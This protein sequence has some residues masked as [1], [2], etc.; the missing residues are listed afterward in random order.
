M[1]RRDFLGLFAKT[2]IA[3][4]AAAT[5]L[6]ALPETHRPIEFLEPKKIIPNS[7]E[8][9]IIT[10]VISYQFM[11]RENLRIQHSVGTAD[12]YLSPGM[13]ESTVEVSVYLEDPMHVPI[14]N[15]DGRVSNLNYESPNIRKLVF[16]VP[17]LR[18]KLFI[19]STYEIIADT[20]SDII[21]KITA[22]QINSDGTLV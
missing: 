21:A 1:N 18:N 6:I 7:D 12:M 22:H 4:A 14:K 5:G 20:H 15:V 19:L 3:G 16:D 13:I 9:T 2:S 11:H 10:Q 8:I 17:E